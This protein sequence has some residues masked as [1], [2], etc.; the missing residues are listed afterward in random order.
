MGQ[1][2]MA[3]TA[4]LSV[5]NDRTFKLTLK[6]P[7][8]LVL[9]SLG[10]ISSNVPF[11]MPEAAAKTDAF[12]QVE[13]NIGSGPF[14]F[15]KDE[16]VPGNKVVYAK[17]TAYKPRSET[18]SF[19]AGGKQ[20]RV[21]RVEWV[22]IDDNA[23]KLAA[24]NAGEVDWW[25]NPPVDMVPVLERNSDVNVAV[26]D[27][28][29]QQGWVRPNSLWPP[30]NHPKARQAL[31]WMVNQEDY[32]RAIIGDPN[33]Y[34]VCGAY[35]VCGTP[36]ETD[37]GAD[38]LLK[39][40]LDKA[41]QLVKESGYDGSPIVVMDPTDN[42]RLHGAT[43][44][45]AQLLRKIGVNVEVQAMDWSTLTSRRA[46]KKDPKK[47]GW[48][49]FHTSWNAPD[50]LTPINNIG[51]SGGGP[52]KAWFGW[53]EDSKLE[54]LRDEWAS[55]TDA[56]KKKS[57]ATEVQK[58]AYEVIPYVPFGQWFQPQAWRNNLDGLINAPVPFMWN[59][60]KR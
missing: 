55:S 46:E 13:G 47:G 35:F 50:V 3:E 54:N 29:G 26:I 33:Y 57:V 27:K 12:K 43:L 56:G 22:W 6:A 32:L 60:S 14:V 15:K 39:Q 53:P 40:D 38:A 1:K 52:E 51:V 5:V 7:Y 30:F 45:T 41:R 4:G 59:V 37:A 11:M 21:D 42:Q 49:I 25:E 18:P 28:L 23:T 24:L 19:A 8:G 20:V 16:W 9:E 36:Y 58:R 44:V 2:L 31:L 48:N 10:K 17:N 34:T